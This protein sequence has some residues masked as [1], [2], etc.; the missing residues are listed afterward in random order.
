MQRSKD[1]EDPAIPRNHKLMLPIQYQESVHCLS[2]ILFL[3][4]SVGRPRDIPSSNVGDGGL[5]PLPFSASIADVLKDGL[6]AT[7]TS[8]PYRPPNPGDYRYVVDG[9]CDF[10]LRFG[11]VTVTGLT[12]FL[13][14]APWAKRRVIHGMVM[15][16]RLPSWRISRRPQ[17]T[18]P[19][20]SASGRRPRH[21]LYEE[22]LRT[23]GRW[24]RTVP[25]TALMQGLYPNPSFAHVTYQ[26]SSILW[27][28]S[29][30]RSTL[31]FG[32][33]PD[34]LRFDACFADEIPAM[35]RA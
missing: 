12:N 19:R 3:L 33:L 18:D 27:R 31:D 24:Y 13:R 20:W 2:F 25:L 11:D 17:A 22:V 9:R 10:E 8:H 5:P 28:S 30:D 26:L 23:C 15:V 29:R 14:G 35:L 16:V 34:V 4:A 1:R 21:G 6:T 7:T 32:G